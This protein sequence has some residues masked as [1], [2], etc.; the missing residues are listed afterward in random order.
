M[1]GDTSQTSNTGNRRELVENILGN[2]L[3]AGVISSVAIIL[4]GLVLLFIQHPEYLGGE[5]RAD[6]ITATGEGYPHHPMAVVKGAFRLEA[7]AVI[8]LGLLL[9][10]S[11]PVLRVITSIAA[12][13]LQRDWIF[14]AITTIVLLILI[15]AF[16]LG[17]A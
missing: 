13:A 3:S 6:Q 9:L 15:V 16:W 17:K 10:I 2:L 7:P 4:I 5:L 14:S 12:F 11:T 8:M 1:T